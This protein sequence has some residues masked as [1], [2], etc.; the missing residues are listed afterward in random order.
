MAV[1]LAGIS[2]LS[3]LAGCGSKQ[4]QSAAD[5]SQETVTIR[6]A[7]WGEP[8]EKELY[9]NQII[10]AF[11]KEHPDIKVKYEHIP[12]D[13]TGKMNVALASG[14][15]PDVFYVGDGDFSRWAKL[16]QLYNVQEF[17]D[18]ENYDLSDIF[19]PAIERYRYDGTITGQGDLYC[20]PMDIAPIV[21]YYNKELFDEAGVPYPSADKPM[22]WE[23][24]VETGQLLTDESKRQYGIGSL[25]WEGMVWG[26]GGQILNESRTEFVLNEEKAAEAM[27]FIADCTNVY[28]ICPP[29]TL[30]D[31]QGA[32]QM[33]ETGKVAMFIT[34][35]Y[36]VPPF[37][38][39][40]F[41][42]DIAPQP[43]NG[44]WSGYSAST[45]FGISAKTKNAEAA[46]EFVKFL[47]GKEANELRAG[48]CMPIY[49]SMASTYLVLQPDQKPSHSEVFITAA[50]NQQPGPWTYV[51]DNSWWD[52]LNQNL[53]QVWEGKKTAQEI[54]TELKPKIDKALKEGNPDLF[55]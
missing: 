51:P 46:W 50:Q 23:E 49:K 55:Q 6:F 36:M 15:A 12:A 34:G 35:R 26:N 8:E 18:K 25:W 20:L 24:L 53:S 27:Q 5:G 30:L 28:K 41:D 40:S 14:T 4:T 44:T 43:C 48:L 1:L 3:M 13:F 42:W 19:E 37:R 2:A 29:Q 52:T 33:F 39:L 17:I 11:E 32:D 16:G 10:P 21:M 9:A 45:G 22:T 7:G 31:A 38:K 47:A 54:L